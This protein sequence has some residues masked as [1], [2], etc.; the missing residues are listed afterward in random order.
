MKYIFALVIAVLTPVAVRAVTIDLVPVGNPATRA[1]SRAG[2]FGRVT[3]SYRIGK[4]EVTNA[5]YAEFLNAKA[6]TDSLGLYNTSMGTVQRRRHHAERRVGQLHV[7]REGHRRG[8]RPRRTDYTYGDKPV[9]YV[10]WYDAIRF[11]N[12]MNNGQGS[13]HRNGRVHD[14]RR[15]GDSFEC[16][17]HRAQ[18]RRDL[19][20]AERERM[21][22]SGLL[23]RRHGQLLRLS[24]GT[25]TAPNNNLPSAD[26]GNSANFLIG[27]RTTTGDLGY[28]MTAAG[29]YT[30][31][32]SP[33]RHIR[34]GRQRGR[35]D[36]S[37]WRA[38]ASAFDAAA[39]G[40]RT[41]SSLS[42]ATQ[43]Q[44]D[45]RQREQQHGVPAGDASG[46]GARAGRL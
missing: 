1:R 26:T 4:T 37:S 22:Q 35:V 29:A 38:P 7:C 41:V 3:T 2:I 18:R 28:P 25:D 9:N 36:R 27:S 23:Q 40:T 33:V 13:E 44:H 46:S 21:V 30:L 45:G 20:F 43:G 32:D 17:Q 6:A 14:S 5:Q 10:S 8:R 11:A 39:R 31:S 34:S 16:R 15:H 24:H 19:V 42:S 12:W